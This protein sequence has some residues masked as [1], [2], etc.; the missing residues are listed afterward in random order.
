MTVT[1]EGELNVTNTSEYPSLENTN[2]L[3]EIYDHLPCSNHWTCKRYDDSYGTRETI[4]CDGVCTTEC[5]FDWVILTIIVIC[6]ISGILCCI[7]CCTLSYYSMKGVYD[8]R[9]RRRLLTTARATRNLPRQPVPSPGNTPWPQHTSQPEHSLGHFRMTED[10]GVTNLNPMPYSPPPEYSS[11][12]PPPASTLPPPDY[13]NNITRTGSG[14]GL[15]DTSGQVPGGGCNEGGNNNQPNQDEANNSNSTKS[16]T[17]TN[18][19]NNN[20][21]HNQ[22]GNVNEDTNN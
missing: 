6:C 12:I 20:R 21:S 7:A 5:G 18:S 2:V 14:V 1:W 3:H 13:S 4:C 16:L 19:N 11:A 9:N 15:A 22:R 8:R 10:G 17:P